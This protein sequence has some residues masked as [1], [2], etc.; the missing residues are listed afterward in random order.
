MELERE[1]LIEQYKIARSAIRDIQDDRNFHS[2]RYSAILTAVFVGYGFVALKPDFPN[3]E[4]QKLIS[5]GLCVLGFFFSLV[6]S[7]HNHT[8]SSAFSAAYSSLRE[9]E[10]ILPASPFSEQKIDRKELVSTSRLLVLVPYAIA[11]AFLVLLV[12]VWDVCN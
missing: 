11:L 12:P 6:W 8:F 1:L 5:S 3:G 2:G 4:F 9:M 10:K 7:L